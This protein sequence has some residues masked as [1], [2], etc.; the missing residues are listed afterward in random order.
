MVAL[1]RERKAGGAL[2][3]NARQPSLSQKLRW[4]LTSRNKDKHSSMGVNSNPRPGEE[5][6]SVV[7]LQHLGG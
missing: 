6:P 1:R 7:V 4:H 5:T 2:G 3:L